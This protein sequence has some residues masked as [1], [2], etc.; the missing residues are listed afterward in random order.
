MVTSF[1]AH[2]PPAGLK[3]MGP[4]EAPRLNR[5]TRPAFPVCLGSFFKVVEENKTSLSLTGRVASSICRQPPI[6]HHPN[7]LK[8]P[9]IFC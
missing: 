2:A 3:T 9:Q 8:N 7:G 6:P 4:S 5:R 1:F